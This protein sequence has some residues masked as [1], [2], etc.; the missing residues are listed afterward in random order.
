MKVVIVKISFLS[1][2]NGGRKIMEQIINLFGNINT[3]THTH[4][5]TH[6]YTHCRETRTVG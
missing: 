5:L 3:H 6:T 2:K 4:T 1:V